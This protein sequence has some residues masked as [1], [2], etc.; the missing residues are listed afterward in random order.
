MTSST[1]TSETPVATPATPK[2]AFPAFPEEFFARYAPQDSTVEVLQ[3]VIREQWSK[4]ANSANSLT[5]IREA[6]SNANEAVETH[7]HESAKL[8]QTNRDKL[9]AKIAER[10]QELED[11]KAAWA[12]KWAALN[13]A[14]SDVKELRKAAVAEVAKTAVEGLDPSKLVD[15]YES[16]LKKSKN[17]FSAVTD[18]VEVEPF[19]IPT[20]TQIIRGGRT[21]KDGTKAGWRPKYSSI[22]VI[23]KANPAG[24]EA[25]K[26]ENKSGKVTGPTL[27]TASKLAKIT[28]GTLLARLN[29]SL[30]NTFS[31]DNVGLDSEGYYTFTAA[32]DL[33]GEGPVTLRVKPILSSDDDD[34]DD[35]V[36]DMSVATTDANVPAKQGSGE[37]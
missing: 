30:G 2:P 17:L 26:A 29:D 13:S 31:W 37:L 18:A 24:V 22:I 32:T 35:T 9:A 36:D 10:D 33:N 19:K 4:L 21:T 23:N 14:E 28:S 7:E 8:Y 34:D 11:L 12:E 20:A 5:K 1:S 25:E 16:L 15:E 6:E 3:N 27:T